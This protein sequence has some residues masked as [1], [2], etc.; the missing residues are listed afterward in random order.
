MNIP[1]RCLG[2]LRGCESGAAAIEFAIVAMALILVC[3][4]TIEFGRAF[5][6]RN[7]M[8]YAADFGARKILTDPTITDAELEEAVRAR[9]IGLDPDPA[10]VKVTPGYETVDGLDFRT[11]LI[12]YSMT[13]LIPGLSA[14][15][16]LL[17]LSRR[18]PTG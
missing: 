17:S 1:T 4:G 5:F 18:V 6:L 12:E 7:E 8:S 11:V 14:D 16:V 10:V 2:R 15:P 13:L 9:F 3:L